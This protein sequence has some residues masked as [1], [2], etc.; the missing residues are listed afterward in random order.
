MRDLNQNEIAV[1]ILFLELSRSRRSLRDLQLRQPIL[2]HEICYL[3]Q[4]PFRKAQE[5]SEMTRK[6]F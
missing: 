5:N 3:G 2:C 6:E 4:G 1:P